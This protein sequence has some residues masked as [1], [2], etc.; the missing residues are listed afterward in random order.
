MQAPHTYTINPCTLLTAIL[1]IISSIYGLMYLTRSTQSTL[2][3]VTLTL[4]GTIK[5]R[6]AGANKSPLP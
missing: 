6:F 1:L 4:W 5:V 2:R 3:Q